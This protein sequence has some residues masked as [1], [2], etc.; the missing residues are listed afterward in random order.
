[1]SGIVPASP[2]KMQAHEAEALLEAARF[3]VEKHTAD[4]LAALLIRNHWQ[5]DAARCLASA[6]DALRTVIMLRKALDAAQVEIDSLRGRIKNMHGD[7]ARAEVVVAL[8]R[9]GAPTQGPEGQ[10][11]SIVGR[12][13]GMSAMIDAFHEGNR[14]MARACGIPDEMAAPS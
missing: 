3:L 1:M 13:Q 12:I 5:A 4:K 8:D 2:G 10:P 6:P 9:A 7:F 14:A 11:L